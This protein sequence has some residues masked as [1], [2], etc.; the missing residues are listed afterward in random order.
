MNHTEQENTVGTGPAPGVDIPDID[1]SIL[2]DKPAASQKSERFVAFF[3]DD[4]LYAIPS[5]RIAE[6]LHPLSITALPGSESWLLGLANLRGEVLAVLNLK[7]LWNVENSTSSGK[8]KLVVLRSAHPETSF[9]FKADKLS[10]IVTIF[11]SE[12][13]AVKENGSP[14]IYGRVV[15]GSSTFHLVD[16]SGLLASLAFN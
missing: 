6:V 5:V 14:Q 1:N 7:K 3:L 4:K 15:R 9:A 2:S 10:E 13:E 12:I 11:D 8:E 16:T